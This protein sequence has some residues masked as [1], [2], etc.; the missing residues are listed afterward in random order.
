ME[1]THYLLV[2]QEGRI[3]SGG[4]LA[5]MEESL[6]PDPDFDN[7]WIDFIRANLDNLTKMDI[8]EP[9]WEHIFIKTGMPDPFDPFD[10]STF[11]TV[12]QFVDML[13]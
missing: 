13:V 12:N 9:V 3:W 5:E 1:K 6:N 11:H 2:D 10:P 7:E 4:E 8:S